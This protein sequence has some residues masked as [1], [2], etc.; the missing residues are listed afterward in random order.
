[1]TRTDSNIIDLLSRLRHLGIGLQVDNDK[2]R[3]DAPK[4]V[5]NASLREELHQR[6][7]EIMRFLHDSGQLTCAHTLPIQAISRDRQLPLSFSQL[8][9]W[10]LQE[11]EPMTSAYNLR[12]V[13]RLKGSLNVMVLEK[14]FNEI[15][16]RHE[17]LRTTFRSSDGDPYQV[18]SQ[19]HPFPLH[20]LDI[21][22]EPE[23][24]R[25]KK[26][27]Q[28][29]AAE[30]EQPFHLSNG[31][32]LRVLLIK[33]GDDDHML[34]MVIHH[35]VCDGWSFQVLFKELTTLYAA[36]TSGL[37]PAFPELPVQYPDYAY[38]Q[39]HYM[40]GE[41]LEDHLSYWKK[42]LSNSPPVLN[43]PADYARPPVMTFRGAQKK[44]Q[45]G[46]H[47]TAAL[48]GIGHGQ[49]SLFMTL[50]AAFNVLLFRYTGQEDIS[51]G[52]YIANRNRIEIEG[53][54]GFFVNTL[55]MCTNLSGNPTFRELYQRV[56]EVA[57]GAYAHQDL[58]FE[59]LLNTL[60]IERTMSHTPLFQV[61]L[62]LQNVPYEKY[63]LTNLLSG[64]VIYSENVRANFDLTLWMW[65][66]GGNLKGN[67]DY[68][69][70]LFNESTIDRMIEHFNTLLEAIGKNID[71][72]ISLLPILSEDERQEILGGFNDTKEV[73]DGTTAENIL[74]VHHMFE[75]RAEQNPESI[76]LISGK[77]QLTYRELNERSNQLAN[78]LQVKGV[79][80]EICVAI[81]M[82]RSADLIVGLLGI[83]KAGGAYLPLDPDSPRER[84]AFM[85]KEARASL[86]ITGTKVISELP[87]YHGPVVCVDNDSKD[88][89]R[90]SK[91]NPVSGVTAD[92]PV[93]IIFTSGSTGKPKGVMIEHRS[94]SNF[95]QFAKSEYSLKPEDRVLQFASVTFDASAEEIYPSLT[96][97][98]TLVLRDD[99]MLESMESFLKRAREFEL[100]ALDLPTAFWHELTSSVCNDALTLPK[101]V[102]L[103]II[104]GER[105]QPES[106]K[107]WYKHV[108][109][110]V[111]LV[112]TYGPTEATV[113]STMCDLTEYMKRNCNGKEVPIGRP[114]TNVQ[115]Y[116]LDAYRQLVPIGV[117]GELYIGGLGLARGYLNNP[118]LNAKYFISNPFVDSPTSRLYKTGDL[119]RTK[120]DG[121]IEF[122]G[123]LDSQVKVRGYRIELEEIESV[124][125][126]NPAIE[127]ALVLYSG[128]KDN[129][130]R[131]VA[132]VTS[133]NGSDLSIRDMR[134][135]LK[136]TLPDYM[137]PANF[138]VLDSFPLTVSGKI[139]K[140]MLR[141]STDKGSVLRE[142]FAAP[143]NDTE[144]KIVEI[145]TKLLGIEKIGV[146]D[147]F[148]DLGGH[149]LLIAKLT[150]RIKDQF[151]VEL[152]FRQVFETPTISELSK[153]V[154]A[155]VYLRESQ[156]YQAYDQNE[157]SEDVEI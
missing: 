16:S 67:L 9:L 133:M 119:V 30:E 116:V 7:N 52:T 98:S 26:A 124:L 154:E 81:C 87:G 95:V 23:A 38:W 28:L 49:G 145:W 51:V 126:Q 6:K 149:S 54:I 1:M 47:L 142:S 125:K 155:L 71:Q 56:Q 86:I 127:N 64:R 151:H 121:V 150:P 111:R 8:R 156:Q 43:L 123:R 5:L 24:L 11:L 140:Q 10:F 129:D 152:S 79:G 58:P 101:S 109:E 27:V 2:L 97:G 84:M 45:L 120:P 96:S 39:R 66:E 14:C 37:P 80:P 146:D 44:F 20:I 22:D 105:A 89:D 78:Y 68:S 128:D 36:F 114:V 138:V 122:L 21:R 70:D 59:V 94:L 4:G 48:K 92:N 153:A 74:C 50:L 132:Y 53:L 91:E 139:D 3:I 72:P 63:E 118:E 19:F 107:L 102:R 33:L 69:S 61:M 34:A 29:I 148:F 141:D 112:N 15:V 65:E 57:F 134:E 113:V 12:L 41:V 62:V 104:G 99:S 115:A 90:E 147:N 76:A 144:N 108:G 31:P 136:K 157:D 73:Y 85:L 143:T 25:E 83:L 75:A 106:L 88:I 93:Y 46:S 137:I 35:I 100:T 18:V 135:C 17:A 60:K 131:L 32:L 77:E 55:V 82:E 103:V 117:P 110:S 42:Q 40:Q 130:G 13:A